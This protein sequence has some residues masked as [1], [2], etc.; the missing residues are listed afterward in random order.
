MRID[1]APEL[2]AALVHFAEHRNTPEGLYGFFDI[3]GGTVDGSV[4]R[5]TRRPDGNRF[6]ILSANVDEIGTMAIA[7]RLV[8]QAYLQMD[9]I[10]EKPVIFGGD[11]PEPTLKI[12]QK[13]EERIQTFFT[14]VMGDAK[15]KLPGPLFGNLS[16]SIQT[17]PGL[18][19]PPKPRTCFHSGRRRRIGMV[20]EAFL[21]HPQG[22][23]SRLVWNRGLQNRDR[24]TSDWDC[25]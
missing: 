10:V 23:Q 14:S 11:N 12:P 7:R 19:R 5:L 4:F 17:R 25:R 24:A 9:E 18:N 6:D 22:I 13:L 21:S 16:D 15:R 1:T 20:Q 3:G 8:A 2:A